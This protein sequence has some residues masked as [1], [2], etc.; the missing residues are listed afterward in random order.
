MHLLLLPGMDGTGGLFEPLQKALPPTLR[1][2][3]GRYSAREASGYSDLTA[4]LELPMEPFVLVAESFSG[5]I[6]AQ[7]AARKPAQLWGIVLVNTFVAWPGSLPACW[8]TALGARLLGAGLPSWV[9]RWL[10]LGRDA[11]EGLVRALRDAIAS[12]DPASSPGA[13]V[14]SPPWTWG[15]RW[16]D[17][18]CQS[19]SSP[20]H[21]TA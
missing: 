5:A 15:R 18:R 9:A 14:T 12:V 19:L 6:A 3:V 17:A 20:E 4:W 8:A 11:P 2:T 21:G 10:L 1:V 7:V 13:C 16:G